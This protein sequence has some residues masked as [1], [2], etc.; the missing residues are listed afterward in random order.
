MK[1]TKMYNILYDNPDEDIF[2]RLLKVRNIDE[3][4]D[5]FLNPN[6]SNYWIDPFLLSDIDKAILRV[7]KA[8]ARNEKIMIF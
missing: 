6:F 2:T 7:E 1:R 3:N 4:A 5:R 8:I